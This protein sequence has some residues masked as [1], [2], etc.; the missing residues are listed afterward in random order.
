M[1]LVYVLQPINGH[2][3]Q[4][5]IQ[6]EIFWKGLQHSS[7]EKC[8][9][10]TTGEKTEVTSS[11]WGI[12]REIVYR[13]GY[14]IRVNQ[15]WQTE[16]FNIQSEVS[17]VEKKFTYES[18]GMGNWKVDGVPVDA[19]KACIDIDISLTPFTNSLPINRLHLS[20]QQEKKINVIYIDILEQRISAMA[21]K[22]TRVSDFEYK[23]E[24][25]PNDFEAILTVDEFGLVV[26]YPGLFARTNIDKPNIQ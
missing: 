18:D 13:V 24:N 25:V 10:K 11:I 20:R 8:V 2:N 6:K 23:Y 19:F 16:Y 15:H 1:E 3:C 22:Y 7:F 26:A 14:E 9:V 17:R 5:M 12:F 21:Q 4:E